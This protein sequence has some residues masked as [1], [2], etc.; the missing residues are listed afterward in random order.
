[1]TIEDLCATIK[2]SLPTLKGARTGKTINHKLVE[3]FQENIKDEL[4]KAPNGYDWEIEWQ[5]K[6]RSE[7]DSIDIFGQ[8][9]K[10]KSGSLSMI[11]SKT[12]IAPNWIIEID[13]TRSDQVSQKLLSRIALWGLDKPIQYVAILYPDTQNGKSACEKYLR[14]GNAVLQKINKYSSVIGLFV[15]PATGVIE[16]LQF[17][18]SNHFEVNGKE[19]KSMTQA[20]AEAIKEYLSKHHVSYKQ[21]QQR[22]GKYVLDKKGPSRYKNLNVTTADGVTVH[23]YTQFRQY[24]LCSY[25]ADFE[26]L[27]KKNGIKV[28]KMRKLYIGGIPPYTFM[29]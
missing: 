1:M 12:V 26:K 20:A 7:R 15:E 28:S 27:C 24:G 8:P 23:T 19:Y 2:S 5:V 29:V 25:W 16:I 6:G 18:E 9:S 22:W 21:L 13:A 14:Y 4:N 3:A 11:T 17:S 10:A